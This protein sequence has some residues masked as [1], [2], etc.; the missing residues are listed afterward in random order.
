MKKGFT[1]VEVLAVIVI[2][3]LLVVIISPVVNNLLGDSEDTLYQEQIDGIVKASKKYVVEHS[4]LLPENGDSI[5][6]YISDLIDNGAIDKD[7]VI[8]PKTKEEMN[9]CVVVN[10][11]ESFNQ[12]EY[13]YSE[14]CKITI[15]FDP[16][17]GSV[18]TTSKQVMI[19]KTYG[20][21][22]TPTRDGYTFVGWR[23]KNM[24]DSSKILEA[25]GWTELNGVYSGD[26][27][28]LYQEYNP[29][30]SGGK[31]YLD[32]FKPE[33]VYFLSFETKN[34][35]TNGGV[36]FAFDYLDDGVD[37]NYTSTTSFALDFKK[38]TLKSRDSMSINGFYISYNSRQTVW[39]KN[40]QL[41]EGE[42]ATPYEPYQVFTSDTIVKKGSNYTMH[43]I[44]EVAS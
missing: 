18:D 41:E 20:E 10:Y 33:T 23:G 35:T 36:K 14:D 7:K 5:A 9:G 31:Y 22:P 2:L 15:T 12:Y 24:F 17:G 19:G 32:I 43:A 13:N 11:N 6:I 42:V 25:T 27:R 37:I 44:W 8:N 26:I 28:Y 38:Y 1:L 40:I 29:G 21:L 39:L 3:G 34:E 4:E 30:Y 16:E